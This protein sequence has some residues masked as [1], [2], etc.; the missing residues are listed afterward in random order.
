MLRMLQKIIWGSTNNPDQS[1][2]SDINIRE[3]VILAPFLFFVLWIGLGPTPFI[4]MMDTS[5]TTLLDQL[6]AYQEQA[7]AIAGETIL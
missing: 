4:E 6:S 1:W 2:I 5:V 7:V 3:I